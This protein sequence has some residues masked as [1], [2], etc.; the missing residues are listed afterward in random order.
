MKLPVLLDP[1]WS[2]VEAEIRAVIDVEESAYASGA[3]RQARGVPSAAVLLRLAMIYGVCGLSL[4]QT[5]AWAAMARLAE[6][7]NPAL[8][9]R[10]KAAA[11]WL[12]Q[13]AG[14]L[15]A[16]RASVDQRWVGWR[17]RLIDATTLSAPGANGVTWRLHLGYDL[18]TARVTSAVLT[19]THGGERLGRFAAEPGLIDIADAGYPHPQELRPRLAAGG[20]FIVRIG[21]N[22]LRLRQ[23]DSATAFDLFGHLRRTTGPTD[24]WPVQ[25]DDH[26]PDQPPLV[27]RLVALRKSPQA[28]EAARR[29]ARA[30]A[31][32]KGKTVDARTLEAAGWILVITSLDAASFP[33]EAIL[34][35][36]RLRWQIELVIKRWKSLLGLGELPIRN[37]DLARCW[38][39]AKLI[40]AILIE[41]TVAAHSGLF[42]PQQCEGPQRPVAVAAV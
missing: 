32:R 27:L 33:A 3:F 5:C 11:A 9:D 29:R 4:R 34:A 17:L 20:A 41:N 25:V 1:C 35:I 24:A 38:I 15:L 16:A 2:R 23:P 42:P 36:Y 12:G 28:A 14:A 26:R 19:D 39:N 22:S 37:P 6:L 10:L 8:L 40:A 7:S 31:K 13:I 18:G 21:W 30:T